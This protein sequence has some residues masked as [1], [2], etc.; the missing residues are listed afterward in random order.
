VRAALSGK[1]R[2]CAGEF[3][4]RD[5]LNAPIMERLYLIFIVAGALLASFLSRGPVIDPAARVAQAPAA[6]DAVPPARGNANDGLTLTREEDGHFYAN[7][8]VNGTTLRML[9]D[10]GA[11]TVALS[12]D[13]ARLAGIATS[14]GMNEVIGEGANGAVHG[15]MVTI[16]RV[17][18][19]S[20]TVERV[21]AAVLQS[22]T[23]SLL[24]QTVLRQF[25]SVEI[26]GDSMVLR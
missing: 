12:P 16:D 13:D 7:V 2:R 25:A 23:Q 26:R 9:V 6:R 18:L 4:N 24:G 5:A 14:I 15:D 20:A 17:T 10:T 1:P 22:G 21:P 11:S 3:L 8:D 19:G